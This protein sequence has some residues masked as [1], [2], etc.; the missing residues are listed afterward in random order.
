[1]GPVE[2]VSLYQTVINPGEK[3]ALGL[4]KKILRSFEDRPHY[5]RP[6]VFH[7]SQHSLPHVAKN[8]VAAFV[9]HGDKDEMPSA[10]KNYLDR[11]PKGT[12]RDVVYGASRERYRGLNTKGQARATLLPDLFLKILAAKG[13]SS[14]KKKNLKIF[15]PRVVELG[16]QRPIVTMIPFVERA[17]H[18]GFALSM[19][20]LRSEDDW[21]GAIEDINNA[22]HRD[23]FV[24]VAWEHHFEEKIAGI[25]H[26]PDDDFSSLYLLTDDGVLH[27]FSEDILEGDARYHQNHFGGTV[28]E[29]MPSAPQIEG[30]NSFL[31]QYCEQ[32]NMLHA[33]RTFKA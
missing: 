22:I 12:E 6:V 19:D 9:R 21:R 14:S 31:H 2:M 11:L 4:A 8:A 30:Y 29:A 26:W 17:A 18:E 16:S 5:N 10:L 27:H 7:P 28:A 33:P 24:F 15:T 13:Q 3:L 1:M 25:H 23:E 20:S 32:P